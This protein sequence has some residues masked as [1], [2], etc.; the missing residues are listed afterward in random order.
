MRGRSRLGAVSFIVSVSMVGLVVARVG[1]QGQTA[2]HTPGAPGS[3]IAASSPPTLVGRVVGPEGAPVGGATLALF[4]ARDTLTTSDSGRFAIRDVPSGAYM[5]WVRHIGFREAR[6]PITISR[7]QH[8]SLT[9]TLVRAVPRLPTVTTTATLVQA[10]Y[11][12]VGLDER[13]R[14]GIGQFVTYDQI[15]KRQATQ[16]TQL[17]TGIRGIVV[18]QQHELGDGSQHVG[19]NNTVVA[20]RG[21]RATCVQIA[22][23]GVPQVQFGDRD[24]DNLIEPSEVGAVEVYTSSER[25]AGLVGEPP[26][27]LPGIGRAPGCED[28]VLIAIWTRTRLGLPAGEAPADTVSSADVVRG[29]PAFGPSS[30]C[31]PAPAPDTIQ[32]LLHGTLLGMGSVQESDTGSRGY[33][34]RVLTAIRESFVLP[35]EPRL[36]AF[37]AP[38]SPPSVTTDRSRNPGLEVTPTL[39]TVVAFTLD[40]TG[41]LQGARVTASSLSGG[42]DTSALAAIELAASAHRFP[43][44]G[45]ST[46]FAF[47]LSTDPPM[48]AEPSTVLGHIEVPAWPLAQQASLLPGAFVD[49]TRRTHGRDS[50][51]FQFV[52]DEAGRPV[53]STE[54]VISDLDVDPASALRIAGRLSNM[55]FAPAV[56]GTCRVPELVVHSFTPP[57]FPDT[58]R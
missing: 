46:A 52:V 7:G 28:V 5:L 44:S 50:L 36:P 3:S 38:F 57:D 55:R 41:S 53:R 27:G 23:D 21:G 17:F 12:D 15:I 49:S 26:M 11:H 47:V 30:P 19:G 43:S 16:L 34:T 56:I 45:G 42:A 2:A 9:V 33:S 4:G 54:R 25:P 6:L 51:T 40:S 31:E 39:S 18:G 35:S 24:L 48:W 29:L 10:G 58:V 1:A 22:I 37:G 8:D 32:L 20:T 13:M 14:V